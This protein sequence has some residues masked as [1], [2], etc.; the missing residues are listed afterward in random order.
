MQYIYIYHIQIMFSYIDVETEIKISL[1]IAVYEALTPCEHGVLFGLGRVFDDKNNRGL[2]FA[3]HAPG[4]KKIPT[5]APRARRPFLLRV[6]K[7]KT[8]SI[9][10]VWPG[11]TGQCTWSPNG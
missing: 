11:A 8:S 6:K 2:G 5:D 7:K 3:L 1:L 9:P 4:R 10:E